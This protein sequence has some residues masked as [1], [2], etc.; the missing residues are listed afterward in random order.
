MFASGAIAKMPAGKSPDNSVLAAYGILLTGFFSVYHFVAAGEFSSIMTMAVM[1]QC[2]AMGLLGLQVLSTGS[3]S[4]IS[5]RS[6]TLEA[7]SLCFRLS[8]TLWLNGYL[9][10]D[11]SGDWIFQAIDVCSLVIVLW[12]LHRVLVVDRRSYD[13]D[14][15]TL[16]ILPIILASLV[17]AAIFHADM[18]SRPIFD[19][20]WMTGLFIGVVAVLPQLWLITRKGGSCQALTAHHMAVMA[21]GR[22]LSGTFM[23]YA[24]HD[25]TCDAW[26]EGFSHA[27]WV[28]LGAHLLH[29]LLLGDFGY[30][31]IKA[32]ATKGLTGQVDLGFTGDCYV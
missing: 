14:V 12:L 6:L 8:S 32:I 10:V 17:L 7:W 19:T 22:I 24:R 30:Y 26:I 25:V 9:P 15:D 1:C 16:P 27:I 5:A 3:A 18:N 4:G 13:S 31:Y 2:A 23:W 21:L 29:L 11:E 28:I 20:F